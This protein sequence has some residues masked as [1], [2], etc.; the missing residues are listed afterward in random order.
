MF[1]AILK[2]N[3]QVI[4]TK[5]SDPSAELNLG[6][7]EVFKLP[8]DVPEASLFKEDG[9]AILSTKVYNKLIQPTKKEKV[10][11]DLKALK[12][13]KDFDALIDAIIA[14]LED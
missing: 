8:G 10:F 13:K 6:A 12:G 11:A 4:C 3:R 2:S 7:V 9:P 14:A 1:V 5:A